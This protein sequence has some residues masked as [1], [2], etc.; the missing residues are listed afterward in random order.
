VGGG[1]AVVRRLLLVVLL[2]PR[3]KWR[4]PE[5]ARPVALERAGPGVD[6]TRRAD[7]APWLAW[8]AANP[9]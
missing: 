4:G 8:R 5:G 7:I 3:V 9:P 6:P 1:C 2:V